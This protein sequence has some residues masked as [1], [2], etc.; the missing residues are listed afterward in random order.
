MALPEALIEAY[1]VSGRPLSIGLARH[2]VELPAASGYRRHLV[3]GGGWTRSDGSALARGEFGPF[4]THVAFD[5]ALLFDGNT[6]IERVPSDGTV[7]LP[8]GSSWAQEL[9]VAVAST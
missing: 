9:L 4:A 5:E 1:F 6:L 8:P 7:S 3:A 2:G